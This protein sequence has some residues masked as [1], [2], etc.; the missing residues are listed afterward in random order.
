MSTPGFYLSERTLAAVAA[1]D[2]EGRIQF[3]DSLICDYFRLTETNDSFSGIFYR[4][5]ARIDSQIF[6][7]SLQEAPDTITALE[8]DE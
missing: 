7:D 4:R 5:F 1:M 3:L 8:E 6:F 2:A